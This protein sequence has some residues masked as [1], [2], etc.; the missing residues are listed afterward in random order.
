MNF[1]NGEILLIYLIFQK[2]ILFSKILVVPRS[3]NNKWTSADIRALIELYS[4]NVLNFDK[5]CKQT[6]WKRLAEKLSS[7]REKTIT[8]D[9]C[10]GKWKGLKSMYKKVKDHNNTSGNGRKD[11][12][13]F[14]DMDKILGGRPEINPPA[15]CSSDD[16]IVVICEGSD[17]IADTNSEKENHDSVDLIP[18]SDGGQQNKKTGESSYYRKRKLMFEMEEEAKNK[19]HK[20]KMERQDKFL[21]LFQQMVQ[22]L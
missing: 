1:E 15:T 17:A 8:T 21:D 10:I 11:W 5:F 18:D 12:E 13:Y 14:D 19:R 2:F 22:K 3:Q 16:S 6:V 4:D 7:D 9:Q 20:E